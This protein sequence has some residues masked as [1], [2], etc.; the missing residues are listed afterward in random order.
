MP[1]KQN[2][3]NERKKKKGKERERNILLERMTPCS[4]SPDGLFLT[5]V[6]Q[7][8][9]TVCILTYLCASIVPSEKS[10]QRQRRLAKRRKKKSS[11]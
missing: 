9:C 11:E 6:A 8:C 2:E 7:L 4:S 10:Q 3:R 1:V 5:Q